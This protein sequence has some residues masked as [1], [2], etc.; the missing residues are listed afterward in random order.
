[1]IIGAVRE[2]EKIQIHLLDSVI[3]AP[4]A[5][6]IAI[7]SSKLVLYKAEL[8]FEASIGTYKRLLNRFFWPV[9]LL[10]VSV[11][12]LGLLVLIA[13]RLLF[14]R[15]FHAQESEDQIVDKFSE[16]DSLFI[17]RLFEE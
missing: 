9:A 3:I 17:D 10:S 7:K 16:E 11:I 5:L 1:M 6:L 8:Q 12:F 2:E 14:L 15:I 13:L 4:L